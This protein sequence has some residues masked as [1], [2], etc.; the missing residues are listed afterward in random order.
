MNEIRALGTQ[1]DEVVRIRQI[2]DRHSLP[3]FVAGYDVELGDFDDEPALWIIFHTTGRM[4][5]AW[6]ERR[7][8]A[9]TLRSLIQAVHPDLLSAVQTR[10]P[11]YRFSV[12]EQASS[13]SP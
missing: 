5:A 3:D 8:R 4:P 2:V 13:A 6:E 12:P 7:T 11:Y 9:E 10:Y 1:A